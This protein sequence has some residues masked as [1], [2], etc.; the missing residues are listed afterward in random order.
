[1]EGETVREGKTKRLLSSG[2]PG[3][4][5]LEFKD[6][7]SLEDGKVR[8]ALPGKGAAC[9]RVSLLA[10]RF[11]EARGVDTH[12]VAL[13]GERGLLVEE[14]EMIPLEV[15]VWNRACGSLAERLGLEPI[16]ELE[17]PLLELYLK[18]DG[19]GDP[20]V[21]DDH[22]RVL[23]LLEGE[24]LKTLRSKALRINDFLRGFFSSRGIV[25]GSVKLEFGRLGEHLVLGDEISPDTCLMW[26][27]EGG[28]PLGRLAA[29]QGR[30]EPED[31]DGV[32]RMME[33]KPGKEVYVYVKPKHGIMDPQ[34]QATM[35]ALRSLGYPEVE[36]VR[37]GRYI[38]LRLGDGSSRERVDEMC[39]RLLA[40][41]VIEDYEISW[42][43]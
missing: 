14:L 22:V 31:Y 8:F 10:F 26:E 37:V 4:L 42:G 38:I 33:E 3:R 6:E 23:R 11:L 1:M 19:K 40:N 9:A 30:R 27:G 34:G 21:T 29:L 15:V 41:P 43:D 18:D 17:E 7:V 12:L 35:N 5:V 24:E 39:R 13:A 25:L 16:A 2:V 32:V 36:D 20:L 28:R